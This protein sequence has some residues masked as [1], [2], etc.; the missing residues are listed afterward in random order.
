[1]CPPPRKSLVKGERF[2]RSEG[3]PELTALHRAGYL[4]CLT[5]CNT[6]GFCVISTTVF[7]P[8]SLHHEYRTMAVGHN[9]SCP[10]HFPLIP[11]SSHSLSHF[12]FLLLP[13][14]SP[15][16]LPFSPFPPSSPFS[17][18]C[19]SSSLPC[20]SLPILQMLVAQSAANLEDVRFEAASVAAKILLEQVG[21]SG[22]R[23]PLS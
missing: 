11:S 16:R 9:S 6:C 13:S 1:M 21:L 8:H 23:T 2:I 3:R 17:S 22:D 7:I 19:F 20:F 15:S 4:Y 12:P 18:V 10:Y 14:L 5:T